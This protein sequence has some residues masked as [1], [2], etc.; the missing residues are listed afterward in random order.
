VGQHPVFEPLAAEAR[1]LAQQAQ[2]GGDTRFLTSQPNWDPFEFVDLC[3]HGL[4]SGGDLDQ[5]ARRIA[6]REWQLLFDYCFRC[7]V[8]N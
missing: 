4:R 5:L 1:D 8:G 6:G 7:A 3:A 2:L